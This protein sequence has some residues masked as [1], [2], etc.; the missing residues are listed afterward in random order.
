MLDTI[1]S[2]NY[3]DDKLT[4]FLH[5]LAAEDPSKTN[6]EETTLG[7][8]LCHLKNEDATQLKQRHQSLLQF[9]LGSLREI[10]EKIDEYQSVQTEEQK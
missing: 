8:R 4:Q 2:N 1:I 3:I 5:I 7:K 9:F 6:P 10:N